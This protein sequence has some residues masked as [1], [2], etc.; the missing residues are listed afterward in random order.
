M[1]LEGGAKG[2]MVIRVALP[3]SLYH[4]ADPVNLQSQELAIGQVNYLHC[5]DQ[6]YK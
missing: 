6:V 5:C 4:S 2:H 3:R 1:G